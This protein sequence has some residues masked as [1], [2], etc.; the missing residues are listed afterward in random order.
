MSERVCFRL[1]V[2]PALVGSYAEA[3][4]AVWPEMRAALTEA[5]WHNY[6]IFLDDDGT[7]IGYLECEDFARAQQAMAAT[8]VNARWQAAM[9]PYFTTLVDQRADEAM[10]PLPEVFHLD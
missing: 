6:S 4:A 10:R 2:D 7:V 5:G 8:E 9:Q 1:R 3:H